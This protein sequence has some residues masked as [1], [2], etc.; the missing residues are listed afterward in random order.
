MANILL[1]EPEYHCKYPP[2]GLMKIAYYHKEIRKDFV[3]FSKG[4]VP[5]YVSDKVKERLYKSKYYIDKYGNNLKDFIKSVDNI[6]LQKKW[7]RV[8][9]STLFTYEWK[10]TIDTIEYVKTLVADKSNVYSGGILATL[11]AEEFEKTTGIKPV[12]GQLF[13]SLLIGYDD[14]VNI[15]TLTPDYSILDNIEYIYPSNN[16]YFAYAT[17][18]C[19]MNCEFCAVKTLEPEYMSYISIKDQINEIKE[20]YGE[21][22]DLLLM[23]N[24]V[25][26]SK[27]FN[28]IIDEIIELGFGRG[29]TYINPATGKKNN[30][31]VDFNQG[32]D[33]L[34][35]NEEKVKLL[36]KIALRP[37]RIAFDHIADEKNYLKALNLAVKYDITHLSNYLLYNADEF[38]CKGIKYEADKPEDL[39]NRLRINVDYQDMIN[40]RRQKEKKERIHIFSFPMRYIP[41]DAKERRYV[42]E[43]YWNMKYLRAIQIIL[44]PTQGKGVSSKSF[45]EAAFGKNVDEYMMVLLMPEDYIATRGKPEKISRISEDER[46]K[47]KEEFEIWEGLRKE[48]IKLYNNLTKEQKIKFKE[49]ISKNEFTTEIVKSID[50]KEIRKIFIHYFSEFRIITVLEELE[51]QMEDELMEEIICYI[52]SEC[53]LMMKHLAKYIIKFKLNSTQIKSFFRFFGQDAVNELIDIWAHDNYENERVIELLGYTTSAYVNPYYLTLIKWCSKLNLLTV[54]E[55]NRLI[56]ALKQNNKSTI[57]ELLADKY[58]KIFETLTSNYS[59]IIDKKQLDSLLLEVKNKLVYQLSLFN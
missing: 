49:I 18:G 36:S 37:A 10:I 22:K 27:D 19:G 5:A 45:F 55:C 6:I 28:K 47:K 8:Y 26:K 50:Y 44:I 53:K 17:R 14:G 43:K 4:K 58:D 24:N 57:N 39:Y 59:S 9:V 12:K 46:L 2:L 11:M 13:D 15:D 54:S 51:V 40:K 3:W 38:V 42:S 25:L 35:F 30:R 21:K 23:D 33:A 41:L 56:M 31:Y 20:K 7:D 16:A 52:T 34:L 48:W 1:I 29:A 32:L